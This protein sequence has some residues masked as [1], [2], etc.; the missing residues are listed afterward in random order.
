MYL[1]PYHGGPSPSS[2]SQQQQQQHMSMVRS[3]ADSSVQ[4][5]SVCPTS[6]PVSSSSM[7]HQHGAASLHDRLSAA[8]EMNSAPSGPGNSRKSKEKMAAANAAANASAADYACGQQQ[9]QQHRMAPYPTPQQYMLN[10]RAKYSGGPSSDTTSPEV[11]IE[12]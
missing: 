11:N 6:N 3:S 10:K 2:S 4:Q 5:S 8:N 12:R 9:Q 7:Q 1:S